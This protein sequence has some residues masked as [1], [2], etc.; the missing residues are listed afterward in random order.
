MLNSAQAV[1]RWRLG[2]RPELGLLDKLSGMLRAKAAEGPSRPPDFSD[3][4]WLFAASDYSGQHAEAPYEAY[5]ILLADVAGC[6]KWEASRRTIRSRW[7]RDGRRL[8]YKSLR[9]RQQ[10]RALMP[11]LGAADSIHGLVVT[12]LVDRDIDNLFRLPEEERTEEYLGVF[13]AWPRA[14]LERLL[15][16]VHLLSL[17][18][19]G[20]SHPQQNLVWITDQDE[21][22]ANPERLQQLVTAFANVASHYLGHSLGHLR[23]GT[24]ESD[25]GTR[26]LEDLVAIAD[27]A[28][29]AAADSLGRYRGVR[30]WPAPTGIVVPAAGGTPGK[31]TMIMSWYGRDD[32][33]SLKRFIYLIDQHADSGKRRVSALQ[34]HPSGLTA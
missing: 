34:I 10:E 22:A 11:F 5:S 2:P 32:D 27:L 14:S 33:S 21:I 7:L 16:V 17:L 9:D 30:G 1:D 6:A 25:T 26:D 15:R 28:A 3:S 24:T 20:L 19:A 29:G 18:V 31:A 23:V 4:K 12:V 8:S 13:A